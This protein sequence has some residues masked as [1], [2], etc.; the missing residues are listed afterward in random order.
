MDSNTESNAMDIMDPAIAGI[1]FRQALT[2]LADRSSCEEHDHD[3]KGCHTHQT[4]ELRSM[5]QTIDLLENSVRTAT[6][7]NNN[8]E[9]TGSTTTTTTTCDE[10]TQKKQQQEEARQK[11]MQEMDAKLQTMTVKELLQLDQALSGTSSASIIITREKLGGV[12]LLRLRGL[13]KNLWEGIDAQE[14]INNLRE[15]WEK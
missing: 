13:G 4:K 3:K 11:R 10:A 12:D 6:T 7:N 5:G 1:D 8:N 14:C 15:E 2:I 9:I